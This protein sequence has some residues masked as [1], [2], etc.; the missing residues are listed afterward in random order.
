MSENEELLE[1]IGTIVKKITSLE[2]RLIAIEVIL[3]ERKPQ[4]NEA[5]KWSEWA[6]KLI[7]L[8]VGTLLGWIAKILFGS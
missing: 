6:R 3:K 8:V 4:G 1:A 7:W 5:S 2:K